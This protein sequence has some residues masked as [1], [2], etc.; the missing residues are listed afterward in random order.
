MPHERPLVHGTT[1]PSLNDLLRSGMT[2]RG[3]IS[4]FTPSPVHS[5]HAPYGELNENMRGASSSKLS[6][7]CRHANFSE[8]LSSSSPSF[9]RPTTF[10]PPTFLPPTFL[11]PPFLPSTR[12]TS[13]V[14][15]PCVRR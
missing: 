4:I 15:V 9:A 6:P 5:G 8:K 2:R 7:Q 11:P 12:S 10:L 3:S 14:I 13:A 1:A